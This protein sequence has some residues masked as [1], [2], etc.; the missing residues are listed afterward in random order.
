MSE[1]AKFEQSERERQLCENAALVAAALKQLLP[2][3]KEE[4]KPKPWWQIVL[5]SSGGA[6]LITVVIGGRLAK[7]VGQWITNEYQKGM[8]ERE[9]ILA[10]YK[11]YLGQGKETVTH[12]YELVGAVISAL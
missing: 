1:D 7:V 4:S 8:K 5:E 9:I 11:E 12:A 6:A 2:E 3:K 10:T